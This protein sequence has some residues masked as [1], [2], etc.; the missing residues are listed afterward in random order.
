MIGEHGLTSMTCVPFRNP[1]GAGLAAGLHEHS[2]FVES[3]TVN[4]DRRVV[5]LEIFVC[6]PVT[7]RNEVLASE[8]RCLVDMCDDTPELVS[9]N[10][11]TVF[12]KDVVSASSARNNFGHEDFL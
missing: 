6:E 3:A 4:D 5:L 12:E 8:R 1:I 11:S 7:R 2:L 10:R 9:L